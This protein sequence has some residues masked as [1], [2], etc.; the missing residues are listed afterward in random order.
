MNN[1]KKTLLNFH[2]I[3]WTGAWWF[4]GMVIY[5]HNEIIA[6]ACA[7]Y[8]LFDLICTKCLP[9][10]IE[11]YYGAIW[12]LTFLLLGF[13]YH[14]EGLIQILIWTNFTNRIFRPQLEKEDNN[15]T[16]KEDEKSNKSIC[17][18]KDKNE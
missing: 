5:N 15:N 10:K 13:Y 7:T 6:V 8:Y 17:L 18:K 4:M 14:N 16:I 2:T 1:L 3:Y 12:L 9:K 11:N